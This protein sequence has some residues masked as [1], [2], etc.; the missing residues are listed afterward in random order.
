MIVF[1][2]TGLLLSVNAEKGFRAR[3]QVI[4]FIAQEVGFWRSSGSLQPKRIFFIPGP[5]VPVRVATPDRL[6]IRIR[7]T[8]YPLNGFLSYFIENMLTSLPSAL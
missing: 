5:N 4:L 6:D 8:G 2:L 7:Q 3:R 1:T